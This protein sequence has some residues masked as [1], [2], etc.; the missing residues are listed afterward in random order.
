MVTLSGEELLERMAELPEEGEKDASSFA[1]LPDDLDADDRDVFTLLLIGSDAY[2]DN[3]RGRSDTT[4]LVQVD[5]DSKTIRVVSFLRDTY[6]A[7]P[8]KG[9]NRI[10]ASYSWGGES[11]LRRTLE[12]NFGVTADAY[13]EVNFERLVKVIDAIGGIDVEVS[14]RERTQVNSILR[15]YNEKIGDPEEDQLLTESGL[16]HLTGKQALCFSR[17]ARSTATPS[18]PPPAQGHRSS[19]R[20]GHDPRLSANTALVLR[21]WTPSNRPDP[22]RRRDADSP[23]HP[24]QECR[25]R[26]ADHPPKGDVFHPHHRRHVG[27]RPQPEAEQ[28]PSAGVP[29]PEG[30]MTMTMLPPLP[31]TLS[32]LLREQYG[33]A[34]TERIIAGYKARRPV[35]LRVNTLRSEKGQVCAQLTEASIAWR[36]GPGT[37]TR[38]CC[39]IA[40]DRWRP[41]PSSAGRGVPAESVLHVPPLLMNPS[42]GRPSWTWRRPPAARP[43]RS[44]RSPAAGR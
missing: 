40:E 37:L 6:V 43:R 34:L 26:D 24:L 33:D 38:W 19:Y 22:C 32:A 18:A 28:G 2:T 20:K 8:G 21:T 15:F 3:T 30:G 42:P 12:S 36:E 31:D 17:I 11:L 44:P 7:I 35:T 16:V 14:E 10:N 1:V 9:S 5:A 29:G 39:R 41:C 4:M 27:D 25:L 13:L 23:G